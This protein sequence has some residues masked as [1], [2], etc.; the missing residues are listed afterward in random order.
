MPLKQVVYSL[1]SLNVHLFRPTSTN[2][3]DA[4]FLC[5]QQGEILDINKLTCESL[6]YSREE[7]LSLPVRLPAT[8]KP[9][10]ECRR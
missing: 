2:T 7:L 6:A 4:I 9:R 8:P 5:D 3:A 10:H 1:F